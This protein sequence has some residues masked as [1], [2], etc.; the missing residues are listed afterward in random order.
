MSYES[1]EICLDRLLDEVFSIERYSATPSIER[2]KKGSVKLSKAIKE[3]QE[4][5]SERGVRNES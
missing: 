4:M 1:I 2:I 3:T 5:K